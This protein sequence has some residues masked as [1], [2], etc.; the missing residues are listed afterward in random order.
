[1]LRR[2]L[3]QGILG[4]MIPPVIVRADSLMKMVIPKVP[5]ESILNIDP[6]TFGKSYFTMESWL[7]ISSPNLEGYHHVCVVNNN[8]VRKEYLDGIVTRV[9]YLKKELPGFGMTLDQDNFL[10]VTDSFGMVKRFGDLR[11]TTGVARIIDLN[12]TIPQYFLDT[13]FVANTGF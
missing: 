5:V 4:A 7:D 10:H 12:P 6:L 2:S 1:M 9:G 8:G 13:N 11:L 3:L